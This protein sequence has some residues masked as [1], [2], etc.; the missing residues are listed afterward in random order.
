MPQNKP[1]PRRFVRLSRACARAWR[2]RARARVARRDALCKRAPRAPR[3][4]HCRRACRVPAGG[5]SWSR[6]APHVARVRAVDACARARVTCPRATRAGATRARLPCAGRVPVVRPSCARR[7][8]AVAPVDTGGPALC[9]G[10]RQRVRAGACARSMPATKKNRWAQK[11]ARVRGR[12]VRV[13]LG[14]G[15]C[16]RTM[17]ARACAGRARGHTARAQSGASL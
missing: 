6:R 7:G 15:A 10:A 3:R 5:P 1:F 16:A 9:A 2:M 4:A 17:R 12:R 11:R 13:R 14:A 8:R